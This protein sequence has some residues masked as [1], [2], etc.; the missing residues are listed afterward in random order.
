[1]ATD[2]DI[3]GKHPCVMLSLSG[4]W[5]PLPDEGA[6]ILARGG[7]F[8]YTPKDKKGNPIG[9]YFC[10]NDCQI[11][12]TRFPGDKAQ[13]D[14]EKIVVFSHKFPIDRWSYDNLATQ[15]LETPEDFKEYA[16][17]IL[18]NTFFMLPLTDKK[19]LRVRPI[20]WR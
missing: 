8:L 5:L 17:I 7:L 3:T 15:L 19:L 20:M 18:N 13:M 12:V 4:T 6:A 2:S 14:F 11:A 1:M 9:E 10:Y 16:H